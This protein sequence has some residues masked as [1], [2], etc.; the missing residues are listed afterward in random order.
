MLRID[1]EGQLCRPPVVRRLFKEIYFCPDFAGKK[2]FRITRHNAYNPS[3][4]QW[5]GQYRKPEAG[6]L[7]LAMNRHKQSP[8]NTWYIGDRPEDEV[9][10]H[11]AEVKFEWAEQWLKTYSEAQRRPGEIPLES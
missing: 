1:L 10:A 3:K 9:A 6:M 8:Q 2:C 4:T 5:S 7:K 11:R